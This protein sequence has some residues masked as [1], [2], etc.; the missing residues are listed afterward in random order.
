[1]FVGPAFSGFPGLSVS[2]YPMFYTMKRLIVI[3]VV[4]F[5]VTIPVFSGDISATG[6]GNTADEAK[7]NAKRSLAE[8]IFPVIVSSSVS[9][10]SS[11]SSKASFSAESYSQVVGL[12]VFVDYEEISL[13]S[14]QKK[15]SKYGYAAILRD[16][17]STVKQYVNKAKEA[18]QN[19]E[20]Y[21]QKTTSGNI[22]EKV[23]NYKKALSSYLEYSNYSTVLTR[24]G[25]GDEV[26]ELGI[27]KTY[28]ILQ[29][30]FSSALIEQ[31]NNLD[32][33]GNQSNLVAQARKENEER[34]KQ[35]EKDLAD[36]KAQK[37]EALL[38]EQMLWEAKVQEMMNSFVE[39]T[40]GIAVSTVVSAA[41]YDDFSSMCDDVIKAI[42]NFNGICD[43]YEE[44]INS[45]NR[46]IDKAIA[47]EAQAI[48][49]RA[50]RAGQL[51]NGKPVAAAIAAREE[52][53]DAMKK[54]QEENRANNI[55]YIEANF[56]PIIQT[57]YDLIV[58]SISKLEETRFVD[59]LS[60]GN[61]TVIY[62]NYDAGELSWNMILNHKKLSGISSQFVL[63]YANVTGDSNPDIND[64]NYLN[65]VDAYLKLLRNGQFWNNNDIVIHYSVTV[66]KTGFQ[67]SVD[68]ASLQLNT[69]GNKKIDLALSGDNHFKSQNLE[70]WN[71]SSYDWLKSSSRL[72]SL[73]T[74]NEATA[75]SGSSYPATSTTSSRTTASGSTTTVNKGFAS[76]FSLSLRANM[77]LTIELKD[78]EDSGSG[79]KTYTGDAGFLMSFDFYL[80]YGSGS[81]GIGVS[82]FFWG[83]GDESYYAGLNLLFV[84]NYSALFP[85]LTFLDCYS[86]I[87][88]GFSKGEANLIITFLGLEM[89]GISS[90]SIGIGMISNKKVDEHPR[91]FVNLGYKIR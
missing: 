79:S 71:V 22:N 41:D 57:G 91:L 5:I 37:N 55:S 23:E 18:K 30:E 28:N 25:H 83:P 46:R 9:T 17:D 90:P 1:L 75:V 14:Y 36:L 31:K 20:Y 76:W 32:A 74:K 27:D 33:F 63:R 24:L 15:T 49:N 16:N 88:I 7:E 80:K 34:I 69:S 54:E 12:L 73:Y 62:D 87:R 3:L 50:Y 77:G 6:F 39:A 40:A 53:V 65:N 21:Y 61:L 89:S 10:T 19:T 2:C 45:E 60:D 44:M 67:I 59:S 78:L 48:R 84:V 56:H 42:K 70:I 11:S 47:D 13:T 51:S 4:V 52:E 85:Q 64:D 58:S 86:D 66:K 26:P 72:T 43:D 29:E 8:S 35:N 81:F 38:Q 68:S 82:P